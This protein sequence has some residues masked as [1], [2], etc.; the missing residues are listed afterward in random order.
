MS[1]REKVEALATGLVGTEE[2]LTAVADYEIKRRGVAALY[3]VSIRGEAG[4]TDWTQ[5]NAAIMQ[6]WSAAGLLYIKHLAWRAV[7]N[8]GP[9]PYPRTTKGRR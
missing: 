1:E 3:A 6:R 7:M 4:Q 5:V 2:L 9:P 8:A